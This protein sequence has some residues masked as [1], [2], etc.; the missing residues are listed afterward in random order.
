[1]RVGKCLCPMLVRESAAC[2]IG[3]FLWRVVKNWIQ[4]PLVLQYT[5][6]F[7][8][9]WCGGSHWSRR[10]SW[11][12]NISTGSHCTLWDC[13][14]LAWLSEVWN[15]STNPGSFI[16]VIFYREIEV[17]RLWR[18]LRTARGVQSLVYGSRISCHM[19]R[20]ANLI[21]PVNVAGQQRGRAFLMWRCGAVTN[22]L[23]IAPVY[24]PVVGHVFYCGSL[25]WANC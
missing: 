21:L 23:F 1:M 8:S 4:T 3:V 9:F 16:T 2:L 6:R 18:R 24:P 20:S 11:W 10:D 15:P 19:T 25:F 5:F 12:T 13:I 17:K 22:T 14:L 7:S